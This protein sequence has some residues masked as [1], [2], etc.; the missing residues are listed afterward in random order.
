MTAI[1]TSVIGRGRAVACVALL[2]VALSACGGVR[3]QLGFVVEAP[4]EFNVVTRAP[5]QMPP[6][7]DELPEPDPGKPRPVELQP[8]EQAQVALFGR[9]LGDGRLSTGEE[10]LVAEATAAALAE[11]EQ[12]EIDP[13]IRGIVDDE[14][15]YILNDS[16]WL[17]D[18]NPVT[19]R[20][21]PTE[22]LI[23]VAKERER[24]QTNAALGLPANHGAF[25]GV[26]VVQ[27]EKALL[28]DIF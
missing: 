27:E 17:E 20:G 10:I 1:P 18:I 9:V 21:D 22:V 14:H 2:A 12:I 15:I 23:D 8:S 5:L 3:E 16:T 19:D 25:E 4:N 13:D 28:E 7:L 6:T 24:L 26:I 11:S